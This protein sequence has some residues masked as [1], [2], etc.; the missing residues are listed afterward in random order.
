MNSQEDEHLMYAVDSC[1][2][3]VVSANPYWSMSD[4]QRAEW[5]QYAKCR[6]A[7][8][9][10]QDQEQYDAQ[11]SG[12]DDNNDGD[13]ENNEA[14]ELGADEQNQQ[15]EEIEQTTATDEPDQPAAIKEDKKKLWVTYQQWARSALREETGNH[16]IP[17]KTVNTR[18]RIVWIEDGGGIAK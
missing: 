5:K 10:D 18:A 2:A 1:S 17:L 8:E 9:Q 16:K 12:S 13:Q 7:Q 6:L 14:E 11:N 4:N 15:T 3:D